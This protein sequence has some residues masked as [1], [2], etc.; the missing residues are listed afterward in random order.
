MNFDFDTGSIDSIQTLDVTQLPP[1]GGT[2]GVL[3][4]IGSGALQLPSGDV[5]QQ[6]S[7]VLG[8]VRGNSTSSTLEFHTGT[9]WSTVVVE[10]PDGSINAQVNHRVNT[11]A[12]LSTLAGGNGE[13]SVMSDMRGAMI[14]NGV[15]GGAVPVIADYVVLNI[16]NLNYVSSVGQIDPIAKVIELTTLSMIAHPWNTVDTPHHVRVQLMNGYFIGQTVRLQWTPAEFPGADGTNYPYARIMSVTPCDV[17]SDAVNS[18]GLFIGGA[19]LYGGHGTG[20]VCKIV[21]TPFVSGTIVAPNIRFTPFYR[22]YIWAGTEWLPLTSSYT[23]H[24]V[25]KL[26]QTSASV[27]GTIMVPPNSAFTATIKLTGTMINGQL[28][29]LIGQWIVRGVYPDYNRGLVAHAKVHAVHTAEHV[30]SAS[31]PIA[32]TDITVGLGTIGTTAGSARGVICVNTN[33]GVSGASATTP[34]QFTTHYT[35]DYM[36]L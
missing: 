2:A 13:I 6:P 14:H 21:G 22:D 18:Y 35:I 12:N 30:G 19:G 15:S 26:T 4:V 10:N 31:D 17:S 11:Y 27:L 33:T 20:A 28:G 5:T 9:N 32:P 3:K 16:N 23:G 25:C 24:S 8:M 1:A 7:G 34:V 29:A 36:P